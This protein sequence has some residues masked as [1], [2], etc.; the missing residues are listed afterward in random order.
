M[1]FNIKQTDQLVIK[2]VT[3]TKDSNHSNLDIMQ[4]NWIIVYSFKI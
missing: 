4:I 1:F 3:R 2:Y